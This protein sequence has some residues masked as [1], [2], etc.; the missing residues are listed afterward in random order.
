MTYHADDY[1]DVCWQ[2]W[3]DCICLDLDDYDHML[4]EQASDPR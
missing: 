4:M 2:L 3:E 1:C